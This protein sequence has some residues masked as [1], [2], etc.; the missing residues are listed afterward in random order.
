MKTEKFDYI[1]NAGKTKDD[2][3]PACAFKSK[4]LA[5]EGA[6]VMK[7]TRT[8]LKYFEVVYMPEDDHD[9]NEVVWRSW[10][11]K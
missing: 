3:R 8:R 7:S 1:V 10:E 5:I 2:L 4:E 6:E 11:A 9:T